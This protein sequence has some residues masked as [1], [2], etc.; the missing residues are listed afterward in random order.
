MIQKELK[1][2][3]MDCLE[4]KSSKWTFSVVGSLIKVEVESQEKE[5]WSSQVAHNSVWNGRGGGGLKLERC[6]GGSQ[7][8][9]K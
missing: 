1:K 8:E 3:A 7:R 2:E 6:V 4:Q 9:S 5:K